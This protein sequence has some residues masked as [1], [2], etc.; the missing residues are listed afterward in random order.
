MLL[1]DSLRWPVL[2][3]LVVLFGTAA[4]GVP[5]FSPAQALSA[6]VRDDADVARCMHDDPTNA[7][8][9]LGIE[10]ISRSPRLALVQ[11]QATCIC[12][13]QNC[14]FWVYRVDRGATRQLLSGFTID[15]SAIA[16]P[17]GWPDIVAMAH[18]SALVTD[19]TRFAY[20]N[21]TYVAVESWR[22]RSDTG[23]HKPVSTEI[24]F[25]PGKSSAQ[26]SGMVSTGWNDVYTFTAGAGQRLTIAATPPQGIDIEIYPDNKPPLHADLRG[27]SLVLPST[28][29][30]RMTV[31]PVGEDVTDHRYVLTF[32]IH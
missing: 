18:D 6:L 19:G 32:S 16:R 11:M 8:A 14:P 7:R 30:Y 21:G 4:P 13:A 24:K 23:A 29:T 22:V 12:G 2:S 28:G 27:A 15:V 25:V 3:M 20:R 31:D 1:L 26:L 10:A 5:W 17:S 9:G